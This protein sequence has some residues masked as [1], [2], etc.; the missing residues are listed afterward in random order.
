[1]AA[2]GVRALAREARKVAALA[3]PKV[4]AVRNRSRAVGRGLRAISRTLASRSGERKAEVLR[5]IGECGA[6]RSRLRP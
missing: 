3:G 1:L 4:K 6:L 2:D 5:L